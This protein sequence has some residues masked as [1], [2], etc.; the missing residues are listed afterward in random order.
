MK[1]KNVEKKIV[2]NLVE[3]CSEDIDGNE[4]IYNEALNDYGKICSI[5]TIIFIHINGKY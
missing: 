4:L 5:L 3:E 1:I 2:D